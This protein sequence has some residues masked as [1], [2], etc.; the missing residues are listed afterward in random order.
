MIKTIIFDFGGVFINLNKEAIQVELTKMGF[1]NF[2]DKMIKTNKLY[3]KGMIR[4]K[5]FIS[6]YKNQFPGATNEWLINAWN[7]IILDFPEHRLQFIESLFNENKFF[8]ILLSNTNEL[9]IQKAVEQMGEKRYLRFKNSFHSFFLSHEIKLRK[10]EKEIF[11]LVLKTH[12][13]EPDECLFIDDTK[14]HTDC[15]NKLGIHTWNIHSQ[16][17]DIVTLFEVKPDLF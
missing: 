7:S 17:E 2:S 5:E 4:T 9:H 13:L 11:R 12:T 15:A 1:N 6:F 3:E 8:L 14:S 16:S 10:P